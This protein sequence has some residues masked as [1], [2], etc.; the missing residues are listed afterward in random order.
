[1]LWDCRDFH[2]AHED[3]LHRELPRQREFK[4]PCAVND[5]RVL[6]DEVPRGG[7]QA[8]VEIV[9]WK[10]FCGGI[11]GDDANPKPDE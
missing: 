3:A 4:I 5:D 9:M 10:L 8:N 11:A 6:D 7:V 1:M 2:P